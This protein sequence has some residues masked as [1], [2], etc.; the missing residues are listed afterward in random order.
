MGPFAPALFL[1]VFAE[2]LPTFATLQPP[3]LYYD[4]ATNLQSE[5][6]RSTQFQ[7]ATCGHGATDIVHGADG[8]IH[9]LHQGKSYHAEL[10]EVDHNARQFVLQINGV[11][12]NVNIADHYDRLIQKLGLHISKSQKV[13]VVKAPMPGL[14]LTV[15]AEPGQMVAKGDSCLSSKPWRMENVVKA[16]SDRAGEKYPRARGAAVKRAIAAGDGIIFIC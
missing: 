5:H 8:R 9:I 3:Q 10:V 7:C 4:A 15:L 1:L 12:F 16:A 13:D 6:K 14:V 11:R 2:T